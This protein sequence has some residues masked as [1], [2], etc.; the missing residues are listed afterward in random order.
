MALPLVTVVVGRKSNKQK[1][2]TYSVVTT[3]KGCDLPHKIEENLNDL[4]PGL[5]K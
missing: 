5:P 2:N 1:K 3:S 4:K